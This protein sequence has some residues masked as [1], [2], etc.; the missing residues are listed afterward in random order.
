MSILDRLKSWYTLSEAADRLSRNLEQKVT[1]HDVIQLAGEGHLVVCWYLIGNQKAFPATISCE[2][3]LG[4]EPY[5]DALPIV[6]EEGNSWKTYISGPFKLPVDLY[7]PWGWYLLQFIGK[8]GESGT[9]WDP[10]LINASDG[11]YWAIDERNGDFDNFPQRDELVIQREELDAFEH[12]CLQR[13]VPATDAKSA[14]VNIETDSERVRLLKQIG[15]LALVV[16]EKGVKY[17]KGDQPNVSQIAQAAVDMLTLLP[18]S[19]ARGA[20]LSNL[21]KS[22]ADGLELLKK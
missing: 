11:N 2:Y 16:A 22:I 21:R 14:T 18:D 17:K 13:P 3:P 5:L 12:R 20:G 6:D 9:L 8:G 15:A 1:E 19:N 7:P 10:I 4:E